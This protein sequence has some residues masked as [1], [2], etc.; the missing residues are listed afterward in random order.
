[1]KV[2]NK[3]FAAL[4]LFGMSGAAFAYDF[5]FNNKTDKAVDVKLGLMGAAGFWEKTVQPNDKATISLEGWWKG[6][7]LHSI[8]LN[9]EPTV[10]SFT[11]DEGEII[12]SRGGICKEASFEITEEAG[13]LALASK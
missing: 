4:V 5:T 2:M 10:I 13:K 9:N 3:L 1:M 12:K 8:Y 6:Y 11:T 7:C